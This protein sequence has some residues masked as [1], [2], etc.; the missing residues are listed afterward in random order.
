VETG[1]VGMTISL[2][3]A[4]AFIWREAE[5]LDRQDYA[6]WLKLWTEDGRY[7][8]PVDRNRDDYENVLNVVYDDAEMR[9]ARVKRLKS[10]FSSSAAPPARTVRT[11]SRFVAN[12]T[13]DTLI[14]RAAQQIAEFKYERTRLLAADVIYTLARGEDN[15]RLQRK[16]VKLI[17]SDDALHGIGYLF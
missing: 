12:H 5:M 3:A 13:A 11:V 17:N 2:E 15:L 9:E 7:I 4:I 16:V 10:G 8:I 14:V 6:P 1:N